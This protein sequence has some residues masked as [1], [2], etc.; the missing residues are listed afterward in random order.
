VKPVS[1]KRMC[2][3]L[4]EHGFTLERIN[5]SHHIYRR[6]GDSPA[7]IPVPVHGNHDLATGTQRKIMRDARLTDADL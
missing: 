2:Q 1:G 7:V 4:Q 3:V 6:G 5:G